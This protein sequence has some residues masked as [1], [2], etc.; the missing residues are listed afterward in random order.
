MRTTICGKTTFQCNSDF[1]GDVII[2]KSTNPFGELTVD[3]NDLK[4]FVAG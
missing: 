1:S 2:Q 4:D 3:F